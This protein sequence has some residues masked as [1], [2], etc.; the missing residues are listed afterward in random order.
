MKK[1][2]YGKKEVGFAVL[3]CSVLVLS[4]HFFGVITSP[5][6]GQ[7]SLAS[8]DPEARARAIARGTIHSSVDQ[9]RRMVGAANSPVE[10]QRQHREKASLDEK[11]TELI[12]VGHQ[13]YALVSDKVALNELD[14]YLAG[15][16]EEVQGYQLINLKELPQN[17]D[18][19]VVL[20][21]AGLVVTNERTGRNAVLTGVLSLTLKNGSD[22]LEQLIGEHEF[23]LV[24]SIPERDRY[25]IKVSPHTSLEL[26]GELLDE[27][28][29]VGVEL[30]ILEGEV[31]LR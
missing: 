10:K 16:Y 5:K 30:E 21:N 15:D 27:A 1:N 31:R 14:L 25:F 3:F 28:P 22:Q 24:Y 26:Y 11:Q 18:H 4:V 9:S 8:L 20:K 2:T 7:R 12:E 19:S 13:R 17:S 6:E 29:E 23:E